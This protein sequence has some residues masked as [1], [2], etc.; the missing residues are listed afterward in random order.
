MFEF[1]HTTSHKQNVII[2]CVL[3]LGMQCGVLCRRR[4]TALQPHCPPACP[5]ASL[6][7]PPSPPRSISPPCCP[8]YGVAAQL[9]REVAGKQRPGAAQPLHS[10]EK[11]V[12]AQQEAAAA[13]GGSAGGILVK[14][15]V[16][17]HTPPASGVVYMSVSRLGTQ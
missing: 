8:T 3:T 13:A 14:Q 5:A 17:D 16:S 1:V 9:Q 15:S 2:V 10:Q 4:T 6:A 7:N 11:G 12:P